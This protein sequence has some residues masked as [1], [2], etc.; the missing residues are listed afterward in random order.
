MSIYISVVICT[1]NRSSYLRKAI[2]SLIEQTYDPECFEILI[3]D[4]KST[5]NTKRVVVEE[6]AQVTNLRYVFEPIMGL[7]QAR[8][9]GWRQAKG[10]YIAYLDDDAIAYPQWLEKI[11]AAFETVTPKPG[12][13]GGKVEPI[14]E[15]SQ[16]I[17]LSKHLLPFLT[18]L[19]WSSVPL[20]LED[21]RYIAGANMAFPKVLL[22]EIGGF[23]TSLGRKGKKL[24]SNE[25]LLLRENIKGKGYKVYYDPEISVGHH[26]PAARL[27]QAWFTRRKYWQGVSD[28]YLLIHQNSPSTLDRFK[29]GFNELKRILKKPRQLLYLFMSTNDSSKF[30]IK[31]S[32]LEK[33]GFI[34]ALLGLV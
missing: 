12:M 7:S 11:V 21:K 17:W 13:L 27:K 18:V 31:C 29:V 24:L 1:L 3:V 19:N 25:E 23:Q 33:I 9:T 28:A 4:N 15:A 16:P 14:W 22:E 20:F 30:L 8:N 10:D 26:V 5:D 6:F 34:L 32:K 2:Q